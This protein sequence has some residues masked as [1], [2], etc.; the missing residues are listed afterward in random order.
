[1]SEKKRCSVCKE[2]QTGLVYATL[3]GGKKPRKV[4][5][6]ICVDCAVKTIRERAFVNVSDQN[7]LQ[8]MKN[9]IPR[10]LSAGIS[11]KYIQFGI[12]NISD[13]LHPDWYNQ[14]M[15]WSQCTKKAA[16]DTQP[17]K[18]VRF[19][20]TEQCI[21][22]VIL[23]DCEQLIRRFFPTSEYPEGMVPTAL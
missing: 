16:G 19:Y 6:P 18:K 22:L 20:T 23:D 7:L 9:L 13:E 10:G 3:S 17:Y 5:K 11:L 4:W 21:P 1:M 8:P 15:V 12:S 14:F 2:Q